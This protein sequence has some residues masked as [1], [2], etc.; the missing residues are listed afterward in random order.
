MKDYARMRCPEFAECLD[1]GDARFR[2]CLGVIDVPHRDFDRDVR[3]LPQGSDLDYRN[4][5][6]T[7]GRESKRRV[8][9]DSRRDQNGPTPAGGFEEAMEPT[10]GH[11]L[12]IE[13]HQPCERAD[14][15]PD[16]SDLACDHFGGA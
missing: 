14:L 4:T 7:R 9:R 16:V 1:R 10:N 2:R 11:G 13:G 15:C 6:L 12:G 3:S 8:G 5:T